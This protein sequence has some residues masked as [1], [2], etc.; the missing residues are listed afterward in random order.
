MKLQQRFY[1]KIRDIMLVYGNDLGFVAMKHENGGIDIE[2]ERAQ[3]EPTPKAKQ[4]TDKS[5]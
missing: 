3:Y 4:H 5:Y 2:P 1:K